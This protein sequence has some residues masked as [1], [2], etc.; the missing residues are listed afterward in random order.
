MTI[1][2]RAL[3]A[4]SLCA[5]LPPSV[6]PAAAMSPIPQAERVDGSNLA[7]AAFA[8]G[9]FEQSG[10][11]WIEYGRDGQARFEFEE[12][13]RDQW[14]VYLLDRSRNVAIQLDVH[15]RMVTYAE[16]GGPRTDLYAITGAAA[17]PRRDWN[18]E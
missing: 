5:V 4:F 1:P 15:R 11:R 8:E 17:S 2:T 3:L 14:S 9:R 10:G 12:T 16:N 7:R 13:G 6:G 18:S